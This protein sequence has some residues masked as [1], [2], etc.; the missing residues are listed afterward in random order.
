MCGFRT[1][2]GI[3]DR[4]GGVREACRATGRIMAP[5]ICCHISQNAGESAPLMR[6]I[7]VVTSLVGGGG[8]T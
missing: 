7:P 5:L 8:A 4:G 2:H 3:L 6:V 1:N